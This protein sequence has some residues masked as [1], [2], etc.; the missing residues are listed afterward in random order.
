MTTGTTIN[1]DALT[2]AI[3]RAAFVEKLRLGRYANGGH[4]DE[5]T[6][7]HAALAAAALYF[8]VSGAELANLAERIICET[9]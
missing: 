4:L 8:N 2:L 5:V 1:I 3:A 7:R 6:I 9:R